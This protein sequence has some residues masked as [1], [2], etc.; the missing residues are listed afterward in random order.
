[1]Q[2]SLRYSSYITILALLTIRVTY[3]ENTVTCNTGYLYY[4]NNTKLYIRYLLGIQLL[5]I[6]YTLY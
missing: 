6:T 1:M 4:R 5:T 2:V 3:T